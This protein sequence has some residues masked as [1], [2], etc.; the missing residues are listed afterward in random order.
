MHDDDLMRLI[1][2]GGD[3]IISSRLM[4]YHAAGAYKD[5]PPHIDRGLIRVL[6]LFAAQIEVKTLQFQGKVWFDAGLADF[7]RAQKSAK[8]SGTYR[9][10]HGCEDVPTYSGLVVAVRCLSTAGRFLITFEATVRRE[11]EHPALGTSVTFI[12]EEDSRFHRMG[13][14]G[15]HG[16]APDILRLCDVATFGWGLGQR[17]QFDGYRPDFGLEPDPNI[18]I[19]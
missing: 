19:G 12:T 3:G 8:L 2:Y 16:T 7:I 13:W 9:D 6:D 4:L 10:W 1:E 15:L 18:S 14:Q 11:P 5:P 17:C